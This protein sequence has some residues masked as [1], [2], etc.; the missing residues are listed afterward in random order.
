MS[1]H[2]ADRTTRATLCL[3]HDPEFPL[4]AHPQVVALLV[5][6]QQQPQVIVCRFIRNGST[7]FS[8]FGC[9]GRDR[10]STKSQIGTN[11]LKLLPRS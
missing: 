3:I 9:F 11:F 2:C 7:V 4:L 1:T 10:V 5:Y 8:L 6:E